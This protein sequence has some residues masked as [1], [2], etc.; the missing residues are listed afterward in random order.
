VRWLRHKNRKL[1]FLITLWVTVALHAVL[2]AWVYL[3]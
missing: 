3:R 1:A 2:W